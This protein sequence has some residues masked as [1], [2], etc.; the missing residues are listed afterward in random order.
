MRII[1]I[2]INI[3]RGVRNAESV[4]YCSLDFPAFNRAVLFPMA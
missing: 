2:T 4:D 3:A 1:V